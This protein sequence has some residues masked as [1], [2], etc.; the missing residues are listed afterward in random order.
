MDL[1]DKLSLLIFFIAAV[2]IFGFAGW[3]LGY[4]EGHRKATDYAIRL[5]SI[6]KESK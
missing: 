2:G 5:M 4:V 3:H 6:R 1:D